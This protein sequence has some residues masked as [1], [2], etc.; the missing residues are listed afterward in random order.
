[1]VRPVTLDRGLQVQGHKY[2][3]FIYVQAATNQQRV[4]QKHLYAHISSISYVVVDVVAVVGIIIV[5]IRILFCRGYCARR[6]RRQS[7]PYSQRFVQFVFCRLSM[8]ESNIRQV[9]CCCCYCY[10][11]CMRLSQWRFGGCWLL[12]EVRTIVLQIDVG[13]LCLLFGYQCGWLTQ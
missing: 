3:H 12:V 11:C 9:Y 2:M 7:A 6:S 1:M 4:Q 5:I 8:E 10:C 13:N